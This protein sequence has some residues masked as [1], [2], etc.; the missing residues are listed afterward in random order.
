MGFTSW[1]FQPIWKIVKMGIVPQIGMNI[2]ICFKNHHLEMG[3][4]FSWRKDIPI[5]A[6]VLILTDEFPTCLQDLSSP[7]IS[8]FIAQK[9]LLQTW[10]MDIPTPPKSIDRKWPGDSSRDLFGMVNSRDPWKGVKWPPTFGD[11]K[12]TTW[13]T[14]CAR[15]LGKKWKERVFLPAH[16]IDDDRYIF[17]NLPSFFP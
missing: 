13:I 12:G 10:D 4:T 17:Q 1:W 6:D 5:I 9:D 15:R 3:S 11:E 7:I 16:S 8:A 2:K 14:W